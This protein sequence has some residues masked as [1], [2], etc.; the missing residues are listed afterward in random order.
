MIKRARK[1]ILILNILMLFAL[2]EVRQES[3]L[4]FAKL[5]KISGDQRVQRQVL[6]QVKLD[7]LKALNVVPKVAKEKGFVEREVKDGV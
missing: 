7:Y 1:L 6:N 4:A 2:I 3:Q 5:Q